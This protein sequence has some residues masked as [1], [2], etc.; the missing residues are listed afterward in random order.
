[1]RHRKATFLRGEHLIVAALALLI[2]APAAQA[3]DDRALEEITVTAT[4]REQSVQDVPVSVG[5]V[6]GDFIQTFD[7]KNMSDLQNFVPG[8]QVQQ[9]FASWAV[10]IRGLGSGI[11]NLAFDSSVPVYIDD[12]YCGRGKCMESAFFD[13]ERVEVARGPQGALF[14]K[15]TIAGAISAITAGPTEEFQAEV[16]VGAETVNGGFTANAFVSGALSD[17]VRGRFALK[18]EDLDGYTDNTWLGTDDGARGITAG[19]L[20]LEFDVGESSMISLKLESGTSE[21]DGRNNQLLAA[22]PGH[23]ALSGDP[24]PEYNA[25]DIRRVSTGVETEDF[26]DYDWT[27]ATLALDTELAGHTLQAI[28]GYWSYDNEWFLDVDGFPNRILNTT[29]SD[30][31]DQTTLEVR[32]LSDTGGAIEYIAGIWFQD[33]DLKTFQMSDFTRD[34]FLGLGLPPFILNPDGPT[35]MS[36][37]FSRSSDAY[38]VYGQLTWHMSDRFRAYVDLRYTDEEQDGTGTSWPVNFEADTFFDATRTTRTYPGHDAE[39]LFSQKRSDDSFDPSLRLQFDVND[40]MMIYGVYAEGSK[41]G[42]LKANDSKLGI[43]LLDR[44][45]DTAFLQEYVGVSSITPADVAAGLTLLQGN[46]IFDFEDEEATSWEIGMKS[47]LADGVANLNIALFTTEFKNLQTSNYDGSAFI[48]GNAG[49]A[50]V[51][52]AEV[53]LTWQATDNLRIGSSLAWIDATYDDYEGAQCVVDSTGNPK[54]PDCDP[55]TGT[56]NQAGEKLERSPDLEF[57]L[58]AMWESSITDSL[59]LRVAASAYYSDE[60]FVQPTQAS[61]SIQDSFAKYDA[62][63]AIGSIDDR[64]EVGINGRNLSDEMTIQHAYNI[65]GNQFNSLSIGRTITLEGVYRF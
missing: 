62:R 65:A 2:S 9:T 50:T 30:E 46:S 10:R 1:M 25:D 23:A 19:R 18:H 17:T 37:N 29:L 43:Q 12:V 8:L 57:N 21:T 3:Q 31:Y 35:G 26:Y 7:I 4:K 22:N 42:G 28:A 32:M 41:A 38:S 56:E 15:S 39:Y 20:G 47:S 6:T 51:N 45:G 59:L 40:D 48:I 5:V 14:G 64:W 24:T 16:R 11:T 34:F 61:F 52:G 27:S 36:R 49:Q 60:Y 63:V 33:S 58:N 53:E 44:A 54:N 55:V 13:V